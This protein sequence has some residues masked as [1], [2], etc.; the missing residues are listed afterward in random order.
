MTTQRKNPVTSRP[1]TTRGERA[2]HRVALR[3]SLEQWKDDEPLT[4]AEAVA[5]DITAG[6]LSEKGIRT[7][8]ENKSLRAR[9]LN[10]KFWITIRGVR[11]AFAPPLVPAMPE[12]IETANDNA[13]SELKEPT[14]DERVLQMIESARTGR[15]KR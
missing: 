3:R 11:A 1:T 13:R 8:I 7:A 6:A 9:K 4:I 5:L 15:A 12:T 10:G 2:L 14:M